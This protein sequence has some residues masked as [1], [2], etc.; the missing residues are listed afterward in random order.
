MGI[1]LSVIVI[2]NDCLTN[3]FNQ[4][5]ENNGNT[6]ITLNSNGEMLYHYFYNN[7]YFESHTNSYFLIDE[8]KLLKSKKFFKSV[9][10]CDSCNVKEQYNLSDVSKLFG[11][12]EMIGHIIDT[13]NDLIQYINNNEDDILILHYKK[14]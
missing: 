4:D 7:Y 14:M 6:L 8:E 12:N 1:Y 9:F 10:D 3:T 13:I 11:Y 2:D 5:I